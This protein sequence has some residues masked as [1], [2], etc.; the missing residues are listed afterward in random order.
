[1]AIG[2]ARAPPEAARQRIG[3]QSLERINGLAELRS[4]IGIGVLELDEGKGSKLDMEEVIREARA[5]HA[6]GRGGRLDCTG[7]ALRGL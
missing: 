1:L 2:K 4:A 3:R 7:Y 5:E 6:G